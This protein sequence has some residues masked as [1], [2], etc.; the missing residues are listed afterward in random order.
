MEARIRVPPWDAG[1]ERPEACAVVLRRVVMRGR[2]PK[3]YEC[4]FGHQSSWRGRKCSTVAIWP[5]GATHRRAQ[6]PMHTE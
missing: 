3:R 5:L 1:V 6:E 2:R 4:D